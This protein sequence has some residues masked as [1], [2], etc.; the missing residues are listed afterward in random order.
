VKLAGGTLGGV[1][2]EAAGIGSSKE[3]GWPSGVV[4]E[5]ERTHA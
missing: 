3:A 1:M 5:N 4:P 2:V